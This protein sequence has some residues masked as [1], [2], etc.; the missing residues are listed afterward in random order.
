MAS[1]D[2]SC[3]VLAILFKDFGKNN[4]PLNVLCEGV[5]Y[6]LD[7]LQDKTQNIEWEVYCKI[8]SNTRS[9]WND[10]D[11]V[12]L[13]LN[14]IK[15]RVYPL[16]S[17]IAGLFLNVKEAYRLMTDTKKGIG[18]QYFRCISAFSTEV[19]DGHLE[20]SLQLPAGYLYCREFF[21]VTKGFLIAL[22][23]LLKQKQSKVIMHETDSG[24]V[25]NIFFPKSGG[26]ISWLRSIFF[27]RSSRLAA[28]RELNSSYELLYDR[29]NQLGESQLKIQDQ[30]KQ[31]ETAHSIGQ[32]IRSDLDLDSTIDSVAKSLIDVAGFAAVE[33]LVDTVMDGQ[34]VKRIF[35]AGN[36]QVTAASIIRILEGHGQSIG[37]IILWLHPNT[38]VDAAQ[39]LLEYIIPTISMELLNALTFKLVHEYR[40]KLEY[41][42]TKRTVQLNDANM[43]LSSTIKKLQEVQATRDRFFAS[44]SHEFRT[45]LTLI[46]GPADKI[47]PDS[48]VEE[49]QKQTG[50]IKRNA[51][52]LMNLIN[53]LLDLSKL[54]AGKLKIKASKNNIV[55]FVKGIV[56]SFE[57]LAESKD[58][59]LKVH[60]DQKVIE[61]YFDKDMMIT[62]LA[63]LLSNALKFTPEGGSI[64]VSVGHA[65][66]ALPAGR[67]ISASS[68]SDKIPKQVRN[69]NMIVIKVKDTGIGIPDDELLKLF[70]RFYQVDSSQTREYEGSGLG[71]ALTKELVELHQGKISVKSKVGV[72]SEFFIELPP[73]KDH[74]S[75]DEI[76]EAQP[77]EDEN[78]FIDDSAFIKKS[79]IVVEDI[80]KDLRED[81]NLILLVEDNKDVREYIKDTLSG[82]YNVVEAANGQQGLNKAKEIMPDL[83][84]SDIMMPEMD[85]I[86]FCRIIKTEILTSHIP[87]ILLTARASHENKIEGLETGA[88]AYLIKP[89]DSKELFVRIKNL[90]DQRKR[91]KE[92]FSKDFHPRPEKVTINPLDDKFLKKAFDIVE[93]HMDDVGFDTELLAKELFVSRMQLHRKIQA[94]TGH[95]PGEFIRNFRLKRAAEMLLEKNLSITQVAYEI[96]YNSPSHFSKAF[97][98]YFNCSPSEYPK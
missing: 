97:T 83:I 44:I 14:T 48:S 98:K 69:D 51:H 1:K 35:R 91:L 22:P 41:K 42:V 71:L 64:T 6:D 93:E 89:F 7:Y 81:K 77:S 46:L 87:V 40:S 63:N 68:S 2:I 37:K 75:H 59:S 60:S 31:L 36:E 66:P 15:W 85:G 32:L 94:I 82:Q 12:A 26:L 19:D 53:Q 57:S 43:E 10:E 61:L 21:L 47:T 58:I 5:P 79:E 11:Y 23:L 16:L 24:A 17:I 62:I 92:K 88:D 29:Y 8:M 13:G 20:I 70:N 18:N 96:G 34:S 30:A 95:A 52:R 78:I 39:K 76:I 84:I 86:E 74:L 9:V 67:F 33:V 4:V 56:M 73:G 3:K 50:M 38:S 72:G 65:E 25:Y 54:E 27:T 90:I 49:V 55:S 80:R 28:V 45:P